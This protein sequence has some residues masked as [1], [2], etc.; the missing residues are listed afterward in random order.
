M[1][2][3][4]DANK[5]ERNIRERNLSFQRVISFRKAKRREIRNYEKANPT[6]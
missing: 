6:D 3:E 5:N 1:Y 4:F 2:I